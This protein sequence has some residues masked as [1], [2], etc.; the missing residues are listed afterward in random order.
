MAIY[1]DAT[2]DHTQIPGS[3]NGGSPVALLIRISSS[4]V[5]TEFGG[6]ALRNIDIRQGTFT[7]GE[8]VTFQF[9]EPPTVSGGVWAANIRLGFSPNSSLDTTFRIIADVGGIDFSN[10]GP[11]GAGAQDF[12]RVFLL[13]QNPTGSAGDVHDS[14]PSQQDADTQGSMGA[15]VVAEVGHGLDFDGVDDY[16]LVPDDA[17]LVPTGDYTISAIIKTTA[18][19][20]EKT[21]FAKFNDTSF[22][23]YLLNVGDALS[24][25]NR[26]QLWVGDLGGGWVYGTSDVNDGSLHLIV[27]RVSGT[28]VSIAV[29]GVVENTET[30]TI[31]SDSSG[32][33]G[34]IGRRLDAV[35]GYFPGII[36]EVKPQGVAISDDE[37]AYTYQNIFDN[38]S[39]VSLGA[40]GTL[41][42]S[43]DESGTGGLTIAGASP[44]QATYNT[45]GSGTITGGGSSATGATYSLAASGPLTLGGS[46]D[47]ARSTTPTIGGPIDLAGSAQ[48]SASYSP[49]PSG[50]LTIDGSAPLEFTA[51]VSAS[52]TATLGGSSAVNQTSTLAGAG[53]II[54]AGI[55]ANDVNGAGNTFYETGM[56]EITLGGSV[57]PQV[58][59]AL[60]GAGSVLFAGA[61][62]VQA[63]DSVAG[64]GELSLSG[65]A[66][67]QAVY[68]AIGSGELDLSGSSATQQTSAPTIGGVLTLA[69]SAIAAAVFSHAPGGGLILSGTATIMATVAPAAGGTITLAGQG[70]EQLAASIAAAG[71]VVFAG[72]ATAPAV[73]SV[74][75]SGAI[76]LQQ[77]SATATI[78]TV[79]EV[80]GS[81]LLSGSGDNFLSRGVH[82]VVGYIESLPQFSGYLQAGTDSPIRLI[83]D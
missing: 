59:I 16:V 55:A 41:S 27:G 71:G 67:A 29:D 37:I 51:T 40:W 78:H 15:A 4:E 39:T 83:A 24:L 54:F 48:G 52:G 33:D 61:G 63:T 34:S 31:A 60:S 18:G 6:L 28:D 69:G 32:F 11:W 79:V 47:A 73:Y 38:P 20:G 42:H 30:R 7:T 1:A 76:N 75:S 53:P 45:T 2:F 58:T 74:S 13:G 66:A 46:A 81:I 26:A 70:A 50:G 77:A 3:F 12:R 23:G 56:G 65:T 68:S 57:G 25:D 43:F 36:D 10:D 8:H 35:G 72:Q 44:S 22:E 21:V 5:A 82:Y 19:A 62:A 17:S 80:G 49:A 9:D 64:T 14:G